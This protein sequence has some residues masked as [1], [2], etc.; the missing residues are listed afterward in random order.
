[1]LSDS[2]RKRLYNNDELSPIE[3]Y[4]KNRRADQKTFQE[5][6]KIIEKFCSPG[7][8]LDIGTN[9][10]TL[11]AVA[12][13]RGWNAIGI[14]FNHRAAQYGATAYGVDIREVEFSNNGFANESV[15][16]VLMNDVLEHLPDPLS[17]LR[18]IQ[19]LLRPGGKFFMST[20]DAG[21]GMCRIMGPSWIH[22][23]PREHLVYYSRKSLAYALHKAGFNILW[24][25]NVAR[26]R[27]LESFIE[28]GSLYLPSLTSVRKLIPSFLTNRIILPLFFYDEVALLAEKQK[29]QPGNRTTQNPPEIP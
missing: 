7:L 17:V 29:D 3:Y 18:E 25:K 23:K 14:D 28:K 11:L 4:K 8:L 27:S 22:Y 1:M 5:R 19:R 15:D 20:P 26:Y 16:L 6:L 21:S 9:I 24:C 13:E 2:E 10:G 12:R